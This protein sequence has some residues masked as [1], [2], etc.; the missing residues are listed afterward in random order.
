VISK[1]KQMIGISLMVLGGLLVLSG[2][3]IYKTN[4]AADPVIAMNINSGSGVENR[5]DVN[6]GK[7]L[8]ELNNLIE[9]A[10]A[11][12][13]L[14]QNEKRIL[15]KKAKECE[16]NPREVIKDIEAEL[17]KNPSK[18]E[19]EIINQDKKK[20]DDFEKFIVQKFSKKYYTIKEWAGDKYIKGVYAETTTQPDL[21]I[22]LELGKRHQQFSVECKWRRDFYNDGVEFAS[23]NQLQNYRNFQKKKEI[24]VFIAIGVDGE[25][26]AP[27]HLY[28]VPLD[29]IETN[30][31][32][33]DQLKKYWKSTKSDFFFHIKTNELE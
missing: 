14:T 30:F 6:I 33:L 24:P 3:F 20:G 18:A 1:T 15:S 25:P 7:S 10:K 2:F 26:S 29:E 5:I 17:A 27:K 11:D 9:L 12:G 13:V 19:T 28:V 22:E 23:E 8:E 21:T 31:I 4:I 16:L 32:A